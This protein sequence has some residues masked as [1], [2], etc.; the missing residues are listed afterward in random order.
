[1][2]ARYLKNPG[3]IF[4]A[5]KKDSENTVGSQGDGLWQY[6]IMPM[7]KREDYEPLLCI[8]NP[9]KRVEKTGL[10][11][12]LIPLLSRERERFLLH[13]RMA[14]PLDR[15]Y[16]LPNLK[17]YL[18]VI[19]SLDSDMNSSLGVLTADIPGYTSIKAEQGYEYGNRFLLRLSE[20]LADVFGS[21]MLFHTREA[22]FVVLCT[23]VT[24][25]TFWNHCARVRQ[26][27]GKQYKGAFRMGFTWADG[28][29]TARDLV[30]KAR[31]I[32]QCSDPS[33]S[34]ETDQGGSGPLRQEDW[35]ENRDSW[36]FTI[37]LQ[38]KVD[39]LTGGLAGAEALVRVMDSQ[40]NLLPH[41]RIIEEMENRGTIQ[42][43]DYFVFDRMVNTLHQWKE[44][45]Y[46]LVPMS[47]NFS[48][49]TLLNPSSLAS[50]LAI[51]SRYPD[52]PENMLEMEITET[53]GD[54]ESNTLGEM[55]SRFGQYG[56]RFSLDDFGSRY[57]N[58]S[59]LANL[60]FHSVKLD[61]SMIRNITENSVSKIM[62]EDMVKLCGQCEMVCIAEGVETRQQAETLMAAGCRYA[63][64]FYYGRPMPVQEF[65]EQYFQGQEEGRIES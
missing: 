57:S 2:I 46:R 8:E 62:M 36:Q 4:L 51:L 22:E 31:S 6:A 12:Y 20:V 37:Y 15:L 65:E 39:M 29:F 52:I 49:N 35:M 24:Y 26:L 1:M 17:T 18:N 28:I 64:G 30:Q 9:K 5:A 53:A 25:E 10:L 44:K 33:D 41:G 61:R 63:Q 38:P 45:G 43:L 14:S 13:D 32:M 50:V 3:P 56:M 19:Y 16:A 34:Q 60:R 21:S 27:M 42:Q 59:M 40:G 48:R 23:D 55:I 58:M 47:S 7:E 11:E 54:F